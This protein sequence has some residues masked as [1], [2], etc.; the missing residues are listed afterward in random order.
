MPK[1]NVVLP[2]Q[3]PESQYYQGNV[4]HARF[5]LSYFLFLDRRCKDLTG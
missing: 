3:T 2:N 1:M 5:T 4:I